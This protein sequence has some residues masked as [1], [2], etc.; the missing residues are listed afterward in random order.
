LQIAIKAGSTNIGQ[1]TRTTIT[2]WIQMT[3]DGDTGKQWTAKRSWLM[4]APRTL[5]RCTGACFSLQNTVNR[6]T[7]HCRPA[8]RVMS[9]LN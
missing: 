7:I 1:N 5:M 4:S 6:C 2:L 3:F 8:A 9:L